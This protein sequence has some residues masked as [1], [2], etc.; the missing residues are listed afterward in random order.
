MLALIDK[1][2][3]LYQGEKTTTWF[4]ICGTVG[5][6]LGTQACV[7]PA[8]LRG[9]NGEYLNKKLCFD[10]LMETFDLNIIVKQDFWRLQCSVIEGMHTTVQTTFAVVMWR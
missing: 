8:N 9:E 5:R 2:Q 1:K 6:I 3:S 10:L 7:S 4:W